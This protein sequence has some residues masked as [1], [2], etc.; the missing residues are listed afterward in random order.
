MVGRNRMHQGNTDNS[1]RAAFLPLQ[2]MLKFTSE[3]IVSWFGGAAG[4]FFWKQN[5][6]QILV[7]YGEHVWT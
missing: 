1:Q 2:V 6:P 3:N 7:E 4:L 5:H